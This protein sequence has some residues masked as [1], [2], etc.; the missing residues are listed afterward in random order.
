MSKYIIPQI[1][2]L[3]DVPEFQRLQE[4]NPQNVV[5]EQQTAI[6]Y[7]RAVHWLSFFEI[8]WPP[9]ETEDFY[10]VEVKYIVYNDPDL[11][12]LPHTFYQQ[13]A[14]ILKTFWTIQL[15]DLYPQGDWNVEIINPCG[16]TIVQ[17]NIKKRNT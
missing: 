3:K 1:F 15:T 2:K 17:A 14:A 9:F 8:L 13:I 4:N 7:G 12:L 5:D 10:M 6:M 16:E 11:H